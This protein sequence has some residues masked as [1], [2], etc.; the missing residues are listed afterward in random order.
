M[1][2]LFDSCSTKKII[3]FKKSLNLFSFLTLVAFSLSYNHA[4][5][6]CASGETYLLVQVNADAYFTEDST[7]LT[8][9]VGGNIVYNGTPPNSAT[10]TLV[11]GC[12]PEGTT[13]SV[14]YIDLFGDGILT[15]PPIFVLMGRNQI[16]STSAGLTLATSAQGNIFASALPEDFRD[17]ASGNTTSNNAVGITNP[18]TNGAGCSGASMNNTVA[19]SPTLPNNSIAPNFSSGIT[20]YSIYDTAGGDDTGNSLSGTS[21]ADF[22]EPIE[23]CATWIQPNMTGNEAGVYIGLGGPGSSEQLTNNGDGGNDGNGVNDCGGYFTQFSVLDANCNLLSANTSPVRGLIPGATYVVCATAVGSDTHPGADGIIGTADDPAPADGT[24]NITS[25]GFGVQPFNIECRYTDSLSLVALYNSTNGTNWTN[26]WN[27]NQ[28]INTWYGVHLN[29][30]GCVVCLD[31]DGNPDCNLSI[32]SGNNL[33][34]SLPAEIGDLTE[35]IFLEVG[36]NQLSGSIPPE[37]GNLNNLIYL[38]LTANQ[39]SGNIPPELGNLSS[40]TQ[41]YM[42]HNQLTGEIPEEL[43]NLQNLRYLH[44][45]INSLSGHIPSTLGNLNELLSIELCCNELGGEIPEELGNLED[46]I[47]LNLDNNQFIIGTIPATLGNLSQLEYLGLSSN[48]LSGSIPAELGN[49]ANLTSLLMCCNQFSG[50]IPPELGNLSNL[51]EFYLSNNQLNGCYDANLTPLCSQLT[52]YNISGGN[53]FDAP[54]EDF[55]NTGVGTCP[56]TIDDVLPGDCNTDGTVNTEDALYWGLAEGFNGTPRPNATT[57]CSLQ[58]SPDWAQS[59]NNVNSKHQDGDGNGTIDGDD[60]QVIISNFGCI[61]DYTTPNYASST[62]IY[63]VQPQGINNDEKYQYDIYVENGFG[64]AAIAHGLAFTVTSDVI[65][66]SAIAMSTTGSSLHP[67]EVFAIPDGNQCHAVLT[68]TDNFDVTC[69]GPIAILLIETDDVPVGVPFE[70]NVT[71]GAKIKA[72]ATLDNITGASAFGMYNGIGPIST[73][74][75]LNASV[76]H[77]QCNGL[78]SA[79]AIPSGGASPYTYAWST[80]AS[81]PQVNNLASG[82]YTI[83]VTDDNG[84]SQHL[85][86]RINGQTPIYDTNGNLLCGNIC[87]E[88]LAPSGITGSGLYGASNALNSDAIIPAGNTAQYKAGQVIELKSGFEVQS[89]AGFS[90]EIEDCNGN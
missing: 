79:I 15:S 40:L 84:I 29:A 11:D 30:D 38:S 63:R 34:G 53:N 21:A 78:G 5:A 85:N 72:D 60:L 8:V 66:I 28:P 86:L 82:A 49:L 57:D 81:S 23:V 65:P 51:T 64:A 61:N 37:L 83:T 6:G 50:S 59:V 25:V 19:V 48:Q 52:A 89:D 24:C 88:Y 14:D 17:L 10:T 43:G 36:S 9:I 12:Y 73:N 27:L 90:A 33:S 44:M 16:A 76:T 75:T 20:S 4:D 71:S 42:N 77:E 26:T 7:V 41:W 32:G 31:F 87:P 67:D 80:G 18:A 3:P 55:C 62:P 13:L 35:L 70:I 58:D 2:T 1:K 46:L 22:T 47:S 68:R 54:W 69:G 56:T 45:S 39:F 74:L